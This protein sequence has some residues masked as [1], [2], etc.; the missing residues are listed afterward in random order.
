VNTGAKEPTAWS[1]AAPAPVSASLPAAPA[2]LV[3]D[4]ALLSGRYE[5]RVGEVDWSGLDAAVQRSPW[6]RWTHHKRWQYV[7]IGSPELFVGLAVVDLGWCTTAFA[8]VFDRLLQRVVA[9]WDGLG[10]PGVCGAVSSRPLDGGQA[11]FRSPGARVSVRHRSNDLITVRLR[12]G[13]FHL[14][15]NLDLRNAPPILVAVGQPLGGVAH[16]THKTSAL[17]VTGELEVDGVNWALDGATACLDSSNGLLARDTA[18]R[19]A[20][21]HRPGLGFNLQQ[22]YFGNHEN[23]LWLDGDLIPLGAATFT[24]DPIKP[25]STWHIATD[26]GLLDLVFQPQG[27]RC[28]DQQALIASSRYIQPVGLFSGT[29]RRT[30]NGAPVAVEQLLG[31]TEDH[32]SVW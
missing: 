9:D 21:A 22:G 7:G 18:W 15:A 12:A 24:F 11:W 23:A 29:V 16:S 6:W 2:A 4:G 26:D 1:H 19:W 28:A 31:V 25:M 8:Y 13:T 32:H 27:A 17:R 14:R 5:G 30:P 3:R 10:L 20:S